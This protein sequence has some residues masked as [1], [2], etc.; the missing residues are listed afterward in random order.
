[1]IFEVALCG[2]SKTAREESATNGKAEGK[3]WDSPDRVQYLGS[4]FL[5]SQ[6]LIVFIGLNKTYFNNSIKKLKYVEG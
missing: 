5:Q 4:T 3:Q 2:Q 1:M 6:F